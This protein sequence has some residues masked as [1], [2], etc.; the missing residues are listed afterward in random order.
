MQ[1]E[2]L[3]YDC[4]PRLGYLRRRAM[5]SIALRK[6]STGAG[7][8]IWWERS[9][10]ADPC[11]GISTSAFLFFCCG[12]SFVLTFLPSFLPLGHLSSGRTSSGTSSGTTGA[13]VIRKIRDEGNVSSLQRCSESAPASPAST[14]LNTAS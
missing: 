11:F 10:P 3:R 8:G 1:L 14:G 6:P 13:Q 4:G 7:F 12:A 5:P 9:S 2:Y